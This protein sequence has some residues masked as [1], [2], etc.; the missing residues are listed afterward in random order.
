MAATFPF[1]NRITDTNGDPLSGALLYCYAEGTT[2]PQAVYSDEALTTPH[3]N[4]VVA[5]GNGLFAPIYLQALPYKFVAKTSAGV[6]L[7]TLDNYNPDGGTVT[8]GDLT[9]SLLRIVDDGDTSKKVAFEVSGVSTATTRT[10]TVQDA[11]GTLAL[12]SDIDTIT[13]ASVALLASS[14]TAGAYDA[15]FVAE[16]G[17][18]GIFEW[19]SGDQSTNVTNDPQSGVWVAPASPG[20]GSTGAWRRRVDEGGNLYAAWWG[21]SPDNTGAQNDTASDA[22]LAYQSALSVASAYKHPLIYPPGVLRFASPIVLTCS[23]ATILPST[24]LGTD[25]R[26]DYIAGSNTE[27]F[28]SIQT[29]KVHIGRFD[30]TTI[31]QASAISVVGVSKA[32]P[33]IIELPSGHGLS[34]GQRIYIDAVVGM[35]ELTEGWYYLGTDRGS[36]TFDLDSD[37]TGTSVNTTA[38]S[39]FTSASAIAEVGKGYAI[40]CTATN[41]N[42]WGDFSVIDHPNITSGDSASLTDSGAGLW[43]RG[44]SLDG[45]GKTTLPPGIRDVVVSADIFQCTEAGFYGNNLR[46]ARLDIANVATALDMNNAPSE[47]TKGIV[48]TGASG[49]ENTSVSLRSTVCGGGFSIDF[50]TA[51]TASFSDISTEKSG[52]KSVDVGEGVTATNISVP[53]AP[54]GVN[55]TDD[56]DVAIF[57]GNIGASVFSSTGE[58]SIYAQAIGTVTHSSTGKLVLSAPV[59]GTITH[60]GSGQL[61]QMGENLTVGDG[62][63]S[64]AVNNSTVDFAGDATPSATTLLM[65]FGRNGT[66]HG[67]FGLGQAGTDRM[68]MVSYTTNFEMYFPNGSTGLIADLTNAYGLRVTGPVVGPAADNVTTAGNASYRYS[69]LFSVNATINTSDERLKTRVDVKDRTPALKRIAKRIQDSMMVYQWNEAIEAKGADSARWHCGV[70]AQTLAAIFED[71]GEDPAQ[72]SFFT[73]DDLFEDVPVLDDAGKPVRVVLSNGDIGPIE[74]K[75]V[76]KFDEDGNRAYRLGIRYGELQCFLMMFGGA[77]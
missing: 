76:E 17:K 56:A 29:T 16:E 75:T 36:D 32:N 71:E 19:V 57:G 28:I 60:S 27:E 70:G 31:P 34:A 66:P 1:F 38:Y 14:V 61:V 43:R 47:W 23:G 7:W 46:G 30:I 73:R 68:Q 74:T 53:D 10:L 4:P 42:D 11:N 15:V 22:A 58:A 48:L 51:C 21:V 35:T 37:S 72:W 8:L 50:S 41:S 12:T 2:T 18:G 6:T 62:T 65:T 59:I 3:A 9:D 25:L 54:F 20:D 5:D 67:I 69:E 77:S 44:I 24:K 39:T 55:I 26:R 64:V 45:S 13:V 33:G 52:D 49:Q 40:G 63:T